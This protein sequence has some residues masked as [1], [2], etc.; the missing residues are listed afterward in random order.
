MDDAQALRRYGGAMS[1][2]SALPALLLLA[3]CAGDP[4]PQASAPPPHALV[5]PDHDPGLDR[6][7][8]RPAAALIQLF[9]EPDL[10]LREG[11][12]RKLQ[13]AS[14]VCVL[15]AY[16]ALAG[17]KGEPVVRHIDTRTPN[18]DDMDRS[19][20]IAALTRRAQAR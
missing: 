7:M 3:A 16:L 13:F 14:G 11:P 9:G 10:D 18:G 1:R 8:G 4:P 15:D 5:V 17:I 20:C 12:S 19:S 2:R 6:V